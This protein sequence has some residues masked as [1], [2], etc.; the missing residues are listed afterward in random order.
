[1]WRRALTV[2]GYGAVGA[3]AAGGLAAFIIVMGAAAFWLLIFGDD[4]WPGWAE[5]ALVAVAYCA[6]L[7]VCLSAP[8]LGWR[9]GAPG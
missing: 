2:L 1:M 9:K 4:P 5:T 7:G 6:G 8:Y 3:V